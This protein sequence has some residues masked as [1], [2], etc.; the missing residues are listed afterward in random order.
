MKRYTVSILLL[1]AGT[2]LF[3][4]E[5]LEFSFTGSIGRM[6]G[7]TSYELKVN[8]PSLGVM[9]LLEFPLGSTVVILNLD[10]EKHINSGIPW[11]IHTSFKTNIDDPD[12]KMKDSDWYLYQNY[13][14]IYFSYTESE[15]LMRFLKAEISFDKK[16]YS[17]RF[18][19]FY[20]TAGYQ[21]QYIDYD[22]MGYKGWQYQD[23]DQNGEYV[24]Y[25]SSKSSALK[26][27]EY[28][29]THHAPMAGIMIHTKTLNPSVSL[30]LNYLLVFISDRDDHVLRTKLSTAEGIGHGLLSSLECRYNIK[31]KTRTIHTIHIFNH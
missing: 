22:I 6:F 4:N 16:L 10:L 2:L 24:L 28:K 11:A 8:D 5:Q 14:P 20:V 17:W 1:F 21:Y 25:A 31:Q 19:E 27:L 12:K 9:S 29:I 3:S 13:P 23:S 30:S 18:F 26:V 15:A 7:Q